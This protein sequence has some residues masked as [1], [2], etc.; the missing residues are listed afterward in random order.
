[1]LNNTKRI[2]EIYEEIQKKI[3]YLIPEKWEEIYLYASII[4]NLGKIQ[5]GEMYFYFLPK[6]L[7]KNKYVNV[8]EIPDKYNLEE[9]EYLQMVEA[10]YDKIKELKEEFLKTNQSVWSNLTISIRKN[11]FKIEYNYDNLLSSQDL[12]Y[13][14]HIFWRYK[15]L[16]IEPHGRKENNAIKSYFLIEKSRRKKDEI[17]ETGIYL[18]KINNI[19]T[20]DTLDFKKNQRNEYLATEQEAIEPKKKKI[21]N[22]ILS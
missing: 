9:N 5:T 1:M 11:R 14:H 16:G 21:K 22:Q 15:Y 17:Y 10:L 2:K 3:F 7:F 18:K 8:Y 12:Y 19:I 4:D 13:Q 6:N 20:Y